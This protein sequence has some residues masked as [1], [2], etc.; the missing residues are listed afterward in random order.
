MANILHVN[1]PVISQQAPKTQGKFFS[2]PTL[3]KV[4][5]YMHVMSYMYIC[6][7]FHYHQ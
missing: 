1:A 5:T 2:S 4:K 7:S 3:Y 6:T